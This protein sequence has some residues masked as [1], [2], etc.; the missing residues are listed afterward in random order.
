MRKWVKCVKE[1]VAYRA[2]ASY[3]CWGEMEISQEY[4]PWRAGRFAG[5][6]PRDAQRG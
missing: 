4:R 1:A 2:D 6:G 3:H 5:Y